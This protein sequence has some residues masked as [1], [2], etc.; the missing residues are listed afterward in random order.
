MAKIAFSKSVPKGMQATYEAI[1]ILTDAFCRD[2][3]NDEYRALAQ[4]M[5]AALCRKRPSPVASGQPR[6]WAC[7][8]IYVL[9][10]INFLSDRS[11]EPSMTMADVGAGFGVSQSTAST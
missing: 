11:F 4:D 9:G 2:H 3:L 8:I 1:T 6:T 5:A 7:G 10:Q